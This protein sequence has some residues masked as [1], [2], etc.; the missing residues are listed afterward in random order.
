MTAGIGHNSGDTTFRATASELRSFVER[1]ER[2]ETEKQDIADAQKEVM[3]EAKALG[4]DVKILRKII[5]E[6][7]RNPDDVA[8]EQAVMDLYREALGMA[9]ER[10]MAD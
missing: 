3:A 8:V 1:H 7:K 5:A 6:R 10:M 9:V 2:L 4:Y